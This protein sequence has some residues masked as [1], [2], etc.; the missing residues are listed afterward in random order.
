MNILVLNCG[1]SSIKYQL[2]D[3]SASPVLLARG[4]VDK[5]A[6][7]AG[8]FTH[9]PAARQPS[10]VERP[11]P[12]H[13]AGIQ[14]I[15][16]ALVDSSTGVLASLTDIHAV[17]HRVAHGGEYFPGSVLVDAGVKEKI[18]ACSALAPL[19]NPAN[20]TGIE[21]LES[22]LP[23]TP[24]VAVFDTS[25]HQTLPPKAYTYGLPLALC[26]RH[27]VRRY[28]FHG[29][30]HAFVARRACE[31]LGWDIGE[32]KIITCHLGNGSSIT[33]IE[34][35]RSVDTSMGFTPSAGV[36][37]GTRAG[38]V[39]PGA[40]LYLVEREGMDAEA[41]NALVNKR[42][43][44]LGVSGLTP[45]CRELWEA[46]RDGS[47][48]ARLALDMLGYQVKKYIGSY[49][50]VL[51]G[52]DLVVFTGGIGENDHDIRRAACEGMQYLG[53][54]FD[55]AANHGVRGKDKVLTRP[56]S[57]VTVMSINTNEELVIA[58]DTMILAAPLQ[59]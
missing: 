38:D 53:I 34:R 52:V 20:L 18:A 42:S 9:V 19:H 39:D 47:G 51:N 45:D 16:S 33:A 50:A 57:R 21:A 58:T 29:T 40:L 23:G 8:K 2:L 32:K 31:L 15:L 48:D 11:V 1:S 44:L 26:R 4:I 17:G 27:G 24:Q 6:L 41:A 55:D 46:V 5:I 12:D 30:S 43:G 22:L 56:G 54:D 7:P 37:M 13:A 14:L 28:G 36:I 25:F 3:M 59:T 10:V 49:A 35:G